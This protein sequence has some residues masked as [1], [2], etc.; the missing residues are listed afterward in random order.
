MQP[1]N[2]QRNEWMGSGYTRAVRKKK[3]EVIADR[4]TRDIR[5][6]ERATLCRTEKVSQSI[7]DWAVNAS[8][9]HGAK[10]CRFGCR[11]YAKWSTRQTYVD[12][13][14]SWLR[15]IVKRSER[16]CGIKIEVRGGSVNVRC[17]ASMMVTTI[18]AYLFN[19]E[20]GSNSIF[21]FGICHCSWLMTWQSELSPHSFSVF[22][23]LSSHTITRSINCPLNAHFGIN[24][25]QMSRK[26]HSIV[27]FSISNW[28][29]ERFLEKQRR[30]QV[31]SSH[32]GV[33]RIG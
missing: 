17:R 9:T 29:Y 11:A 12:V 7:S 19:A 24:H 26:I 18:N 1:T 5:S 28:W 13:V 33:T 16:E 15:I 25:I 6:M 30:N 10:L 22:P 8:G 4:R 3:K 27:I 32:P 31:S 14:D 23:I 20:R 2:E 21:D